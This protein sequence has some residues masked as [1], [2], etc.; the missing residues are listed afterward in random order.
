MHHPSP[1]TV[2]GKSPALRSSGDVLRGVDFVG[3]FGPTNEVRRVCIDLE[4]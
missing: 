2:R 1:L 3:L 4:K